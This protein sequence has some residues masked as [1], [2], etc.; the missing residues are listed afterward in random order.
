MFHEAIPT[1]A[2]I[3]ILYIY[4]TKWTSF[5]VGFQILA[6]PCNQ[7]GQEEPGSNDQI[8]EFV[9]TRFKSEFPIFDKVIF[10]LKKMPSLNYS[11]KKLQFMQWSDLT[12]Q[13]T[14]L[15]F[16]IFKQQLLIWEGASICVCRYCVSHKLRA[17][18]SI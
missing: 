8:L 11:S 14:L 17:W 12:R 7:F 1:N 9:C 15:K 13:Y 3:P 4:I 18:Y 2:L 5:N 10:N 16:L 6:F